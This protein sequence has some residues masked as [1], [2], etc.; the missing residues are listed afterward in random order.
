MTARQLIM[1][2]V[3]ILVPWPVMAATTLIEGPDNR[4]TD[5]VVEHA[6]TG[7]AR[8][9]RL[10]EEHGMENPD[11]PAFLSDDA[12][13]M[14]NRYLEVTGLSSSYRAGKVSSFG[15]CNPQAE[16]SMGG[17]FLCEG[18]SNWTNKII[19]INMTGHEHWHAAVQ[20]HYSG[21]ECCSGNQKIETV[22]GPAWLIEGAADLWGQY[23]VTN[24]NLKLLAIRM[25]TEYREQLPHN[26][27]LQN[28]ATMSGLQDHG[29]KAGTLAVYEL[30]NESHFERFATYFSILG[31]G[32]SLAE[33]FEESFGVG[34]NDYI[35]KFDAKYN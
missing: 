8:S 19:A 25:R 18:G 5:Q 1:T 34:L 7:I 15:Q 32:S 21:L 33:A 17:L 6:R 26:P 22:F 24:G 35:K 2:L 11:L 14:A 16:A 10:L 9:E 29:L 20:Y 13:W 4:N 12:I 3:L 31:E 23:V 28:I 30:I 27:S